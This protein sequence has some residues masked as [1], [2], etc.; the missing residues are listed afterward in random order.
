MVNPPFN[1]IVDQ[2][3]SLKSGWCLKASGIR[4]IG[5]NNNKEGAFRPLFASLVFRKRG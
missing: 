2:S 3:L 5:R 1:D 4:K